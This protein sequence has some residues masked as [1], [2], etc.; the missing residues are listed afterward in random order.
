MERRIPR[1]LLAGTGS[2]CGKTTLS[3]ALLR[4]LRRRGLRP[5]AFKCGPDYIDPMFHAAAAGVPGCN[6]DPFFLD[7][8]SLCELLARHAPAGTPALIEGVMGYY[9][10]IGT[11]SA[12]SSYALAA[13]TETPA[14]LLLNARGG[15]RSLLAQIEGFLRFEPDS[16][17]RGVILN[18]CGEGVYRMLAP[19]IRSRWAGAVRP[20]GWFPQMPDCALES[21]HLG[22]VTAREVPELEAMLERLAEQAERSLDLDGL[23]A[24]AGEAPPLRW[25]PPEPLPALEPVRIG[26][27]RDAAFCFYYEDSLNLLTELGAELVPFSP[28]EDPA[29]PERLHGLYLGGGYPELYAERLEANAP[30]RASIREALTR[31]LPCIAEC[32]G[33]MYLTESIDGYAMAG[34]LPG[35]CRDAGRLTRFGYV[36][37]RAE[38]DN[39][40]CAAGESIRAHEFHRWDSPDPGADFTAEKPGGRRSWKCV[41]AG[42]RLYAGFPH[43]HFWADPRF[44]LRFYQACL[45]EKHQHD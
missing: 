13:A 41:H 24:L 39:L 3:C 21:R 43:F 25:T 29:L 26:V 32:G 28:L 37:L 42:A 36:T 12:G 10:G 20:L 40:L 38:R 17:V 7:R 8:D 22:L 30:M 31:G 14:V 23:L 1:L 27:A 33:Y 19:E 16:R 2:G 18:G 35:D 15:S 9:D 5:A 34:F 44:A 4:A 45:E 6:L 11:G